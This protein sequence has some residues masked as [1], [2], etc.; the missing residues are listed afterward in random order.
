MRQ[1][2]SVVDDI[3]GKHEIRLGP[4]TVQ[5]LRG[6]E[7]PNNGEHGSDPYLCC[8]AISMNG[9]LFSSTTTADPDQ[10]RLLDWAHAGTC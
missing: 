10:V 5:F 4:G 1:D 3:K 9:L 7:V 6:P 8:P 2:R